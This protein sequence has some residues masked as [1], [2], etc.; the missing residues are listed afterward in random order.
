MLLIASHIQG[1]TTR[2][3]LGQAAKRRKQK[4]PNVKEERKVMKPSVEPR[5]K[6]SS[7]T[8]PMK[9]CFCGGGDDD[10]G[11]SVSDDEEHQRVH[12]EDE[13]AWA[14]NRADGRDVRT[15]T[16]TD[17]QEVLHERERDSDVK[18]KDV[19]E[20]GDED[21]TK[22]SGPGRVL[23]EG[24]YP[25]THEDEAGAWSREAVEWCGVRYAQ[26]DLPPF[27]AVGLRG[28]S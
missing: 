16:R 24:A 13:D 3:V 2:D 8:G 12:A 25:T 19:R 28:P 17:G 7:G 5:K 9:W 22:K 6:R 4:A 10:D 21:P 27:D 11:G 23:E 1:E 26:G 20:D 14:H 15:A 18:G